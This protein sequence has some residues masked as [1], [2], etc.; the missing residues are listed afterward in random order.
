LHD[1][2]GQLA[3][4]LNGHG[5]LADAVVGEVIT[6]RTYNC[7]FHELAQEHP[8]ICEMD[9]GMLQKVLGAEVHL[10]KCMLEGH[11]GCVFTVQP[12]AQ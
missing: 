12:S 11:S 8:E 6:L 3:H 10:S 9:R 2:V 5:V 7:P 1:R 4:A